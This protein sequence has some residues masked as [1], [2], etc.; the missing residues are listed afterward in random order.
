M[1]F[2]RLYTRRIYIVVIIF[3]LLSSTNIYIENT[4]TK[5]KENNLITIFPTLI[6]GFE[7]TFVDF[8]QTSK[9][10]NNLVREGVMGRDKN[11][12]L[13]ESIKFEIKGK[14]IFS[15]NGD[16]EFITIDARLSQNCLPQCRYV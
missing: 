13:N 1:N 8:D 9:T 11:E 14:S 6:L 2:M 15:P 3:L 5:D 4:E 7:K 12:K 10:N 16:D